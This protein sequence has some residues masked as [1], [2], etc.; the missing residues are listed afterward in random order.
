MKKI[1]SVLL[2][3]LLVLGVF[4][5]CS[6][7]NNEVNNNKTSVENSNS[8]EKK[9]TS[10][11]ESFKVP[12]YI[13]NETEDSITYKDPLGNENTFKKNP[14]RVIV[15]HSS[16]I[17]LWY[18]A[19]GEA[20]ARCSGSTNVP[21]EATDVEQIGSA[22]SP[23]LEKIIALKPDLVILSSVTSKQA[24]LKDALKENNIQ[25]LYLNTSYKPYESFIDTL[26]LFT[27][28]TD[29]KEIFDTK[30]EDIRNNVEAIKD[31]VKNEEKPKVAILFSS[32][33]SVSTELPTSLTGEI[34]DMLYGDNIVKGAQV[35]GATKVDFSI[36]RIIESDP[37]IIFITTMGDLE[38]VN[39]R[40]KDDIESNEAWASLR[41]V[42]EG[43]I[44][45]LPKELF[46]YKPN[47]KYPEA[48]QYIAELLYPEVFK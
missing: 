17:D 31:K 7:K 14:E 23:N 9:E 22:F 35:E 30:I 4:S 48:V 16:F 32:T 18:L 41:A 26:Y 19:G 47:A 21:E 28:L 45:Y 6:N 11:Q 12:E 3:M 44:Y 13:I 36:E 39:K 38:K 29:K 24:E 10:S 25:A 40:I 37:D 1:V 34:V 33:R 5:G 46:T 2:T 42:K 8:V 43:R 15:L 20:I 27:R